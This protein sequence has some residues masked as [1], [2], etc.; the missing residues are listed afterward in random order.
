[1][2]RQFGQRGR[3]L[4]INTPETESIQIIRGR[5][6]QAMT[7]KKPNPERGTVIVEAAFTLLLLFIFLFGLMEVGR[8]ISVQQVLTNAAREGARARVTPYSQTSYLLADFEVRNVVCTFLN[9]ASVKCDPTTNDYLGPADQTRIW[10]NQGTHVPD[11]TVCP[12]S[13][14]FPDESCTIVHVE[15]PYRPILLSMF[16]YFSVTLKAEALMRNETGK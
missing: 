3:R 10:V 15:V 8:F 9:A 2:D 12:T 5:R 4:R 6:F 11:Q 16:G 1:M 13:I 7:T 14:G